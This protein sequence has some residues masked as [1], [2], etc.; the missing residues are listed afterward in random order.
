MWPSPDAGLLDIVLE[1]NDAILDAVEVVGYGVQKKISVIGSQQS[2][3]VKELKVPVANLTQG[4]AGRV[5]GLVSVQR[6]SEPG[7][8]DADHLHPRHLDPDGQHERTADARGRRAPLVR[9]RRSGGHRE[10]LDPQRRL[11]DGRIRR[12]RRE[13]RHH[14]QHQERIERTTEVHRALHRGHHDSDENHRLRRRRHLHGDVERSLDDPRAAERY[15]A[16][17]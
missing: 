3:Q 10:L 17:R 4:L 14:H 5:A 2:I 7:F 11:G 9:Q 1:Q 15:T 6:T 16:A 13:R 12:A 8:D